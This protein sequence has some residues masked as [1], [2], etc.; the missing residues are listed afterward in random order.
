M[1]PPPL[2]WVSSFCTSTGGALGQQMV[3]DVKATVNPLV[4]KL[5]VGWPEDV[6]SSIGLQV[7]N[8][9]QKWIVVN[10][11]VQNGA[12]DLKPTSLTAHIIVKRRNG[13]PKDISP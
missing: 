13:S 3:Y 9:L 10:D 6:K 2:A 11:C 5:R 1:L 12:V 4:Y 8:L 7:W